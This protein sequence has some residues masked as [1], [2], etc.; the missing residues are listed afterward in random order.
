MGVLLL[1]LYEIMQVWTTTCDKTGLWR[2]LLEKPQT[3]LTKTTGHPVTGALHVLHCS[4]N[5][6]WY[7]MLNFICFYFLLGCCR[8]CFLWINGLSGIS[9]SAISLTLFAAFKVSFPQRRY[10]GQMLVTE[11]NLVTNKF[12][13][14]SNKL[15][16]FGFVKGL[17]KEKRPVKNIPPILILHVNVKWRMFSAVILYNRKF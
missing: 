13:V 7:M 5:D 16:W 10:V 3:I 12:N 1:W 9:F 6:L 8:I 15:T 4:Q 2:S 17:F 14:F 11:M